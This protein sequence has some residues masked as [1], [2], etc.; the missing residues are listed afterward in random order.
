M[1]DPA[2][3]LG[4]MA[5]IVAH[6]TLGPRAD[7][8]YPIDRLATYENLI[9]LCGFDHTKVDRQPNSYTINDLRKWKV[10]HESWVRVRLAQEMP[11]IG[12]AEL[13]VV[14]RAILALPEQPNTSYV[15]TPPAEKMLKNGLSDQVRL[16]LQMG[17]AGG[18]EVEKFVSHVGVLDS[19]FPERLRAGF[20]QKYNHLRS[21]GL[22]GDAVFWGLLEFAHGQSGALARHAAGLAVVGYLFMACEV[23]D[24]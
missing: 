5:H 23:F 3:V 15:V 6:S 2:V 1:L 17:L 20:L 16:T 24:K 21:E 19:E 10:D 9:L 4:E 8:N 11:T 22:R 18:P 7:P 13:E 14:T 12:F